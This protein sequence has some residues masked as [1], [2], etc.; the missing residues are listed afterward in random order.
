[1]KYLDLA[2]GLPQGLKPKFLKALT[3]RAEEVAEKL[4][5]T[6]RGVDHRG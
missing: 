6:A 3:E 1:M 2:A 4:V 5:P